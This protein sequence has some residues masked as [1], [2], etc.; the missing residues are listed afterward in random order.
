MFVSKKWK[1]E[2]INVVNWVLDI[3]ASITD[4]LEKKYKQFTSQTVD[5]NLFFYINICGFSKLYGK[6]K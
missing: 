4:N 2:L 5:L 1:Q 3:L 6:I